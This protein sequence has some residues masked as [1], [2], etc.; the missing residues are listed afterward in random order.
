M[1]ASAPHTLG[2]PRGGDGGGRA[3]GGPDGA[4]RM[5][6][7]MGHNGGPPM[8]LGQGFRRHAWGRARR[9]LLPTLPLEVVRLRMARAR[10]LGLDYRTYA[11]IR[12]GAGCDVTAFLFSSNALR[13]LPPVPELPADRLARLAQTGV[14]RL[15]A[16]HAPL[17]PDACGASAAALGVPFAAQGRAP[18]LADAPRDVRLAME[19]LLRAA[20]LS[21]SGV[22][23]V[24]DTA[25][26][27]GW[28][29]AARLAGYLPAERW[30]AAAP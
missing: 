18:G 12:A 20:G 19:A 28:S 21:R 14:P 3:G 10:R 27:R 6:A 26:E 5:S 29:P 15:L 24:G 17:R 16:V 4:G 1:Q 23:V 13:L 30:M 2:I 7:G 22:V 11:G 8:A 25:L 9:A